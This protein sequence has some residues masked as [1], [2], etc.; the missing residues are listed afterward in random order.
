MPESASTFR[1][2]LMF[3]GPGLLVAVGYMDPGNWATAI[4]AGSRYGHTLLFVVLWSSIAAAFLQ[5]LSMRIGIVTKRLDLARARAAA[6]VRAAGQPHLF[7]V[8]AELAIIATDVAEVLGGA[9]A[10]KLLFGCALRTGIFITALDTIFVL[11]L[12]GKGFRRVEAIVL[13]LVLTIARVLLHRTC[14]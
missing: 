11:G 2:F 13:G 6:V 3:L 8:L 14:G 9:L 1:K 12:K 10:F 4:E 7:W 5:C